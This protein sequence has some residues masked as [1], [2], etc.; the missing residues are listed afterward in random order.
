MLTFKDIFFK[1]K[2]LLI[3]LLVIF[4]FLRIFGSNDSILLSSD[5]LK[6]LETSKRFPNHTLYNDQLYLLHP[7][8][9]PYVIHFF[10]FVFQQDYIASIALSLVSTIITFFVVY[11]LFMLIT[12]RFNL[13]FFVLLFYTLSDSLIIAS[14]VPLR[15]SFIIMLIL[16]SIY[17]YLKGVKFHNKKSIVYATLIG[18]LLAITSDH[19]VL[20]FPSLVLIYLFFN[21]EKINLRRLKFPNISYIVIPL[22]TISLFYGS[23]TA[24]KFYQYSQYEYYPNGYSGMPIHITDLGLLQAISPQFF[25]DYYGTRFADSKFVSFVKKTLFNLGYMINLEPFDIPRGLNFTTMEFLLFPRHIVYMFIIYL[26][27]ALIAV[28]GLHSMFRDLIKSRKI[29]GNVNLF[30]LLLFLIFAFP[31]TQQLASPRYILTSYIFAF[32]FISYGLVTLLEKKISTKLQTKFL[33]FIAVLLILLVP[34]WYYE[35]NYF[36]LFT[37][38]EVVVQNTGEY[39]K[40]NIPENSGIMTQPGYNV[41][42][43]YR[44]GNRMIGLHGDPSQIP[45][46]IDKFNISYIVV[47]DY[48]T[49]EAFHLAQ[50]S[51]EYVKNNTDKFELVATIQEDYSDFFVEDDP[52]RTDEVYIY[53]IK[54]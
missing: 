37:D 20:L 35:N 21:K 54:N 23:W 18:G 9:Y 41:G 24:V 53:K 13:T 10:T 4:V 38:K 47:G 16:S 15:E 12:N 33:A 17:L 5:P 19:V 45:L 52:I 8:G 29:Y 51:V 27:L 32:Y 7:P 3:I 48:F 2:N 31:A 36:V 1:K 34:F 42:L 49:Y 50:E 40:N 28:Y 30:M 25:E 6:F 39:I 46:L 22:V 14:R 43:I 44:T 11:K 26:P